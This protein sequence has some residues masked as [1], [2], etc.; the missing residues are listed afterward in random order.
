MRKFLLNLGTKTENEPEEIPYINLPT[1]I[2]GRF[3]VRVKP[4]P[5]Q[6]GIFVTSTANHLPLLA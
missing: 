4:T 6:R 2:V 1:T 5:I 3:P